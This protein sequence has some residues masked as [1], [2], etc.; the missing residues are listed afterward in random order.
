MGNIAVELRNLNLEYAEVI[1]L[2]NANLKFKKGSIHALI[3]EHGAGKS[4]I[5]HILSGLVKPSLGEIIIDEKHY[6]S[7]TPKIAINKGIHLVHQ[8][9]PLNPHFTVAENLFYSS[10]KSPIFSMFYKSQLQEKAK[11]YLK[12]KGFEIDTSRLTKNLNLAEKAVISILA[13]IVDNTNVLILDESLDKVSI[14]YY[15]HLTEI[16]NELAAKGCTI[17]IIS[18]KI[19]RVY[20][21]ADTISIVKD[22]R[23]I[24]TEDTKSIGKMQMIKMA[25]TQ[26]SE[27][28]IYQNN[29]GSLYQLVKYNEA[30]L[31]DLPANLIIVNNDG[32]LKLAN[33]FFINNF[34]LN[35]ADYI[36]KPVK[37]LFEK[38][39]STSLNV[40]LHSISDNKEETKFHVT[41]EINNN[42]GIF[43]IYTSPIIDDTDK[44]GNMIIF[45][46]ITVY[47]SLQE[48]NQLND[49]LSSVGLLSAGV[50]HEI[51]NPLEIISNYLTNIKFQYN[52][53]HLISIVN[54]LS[55]QVNYIT[56]IVS[57]LQ[58]FSNIEKLNPES[59]NVNEII[60]EMI[61]LLKVNA[62]LKDI[63]IVFVQNDYNAYIFVNEN[64]LK[65]VI[66]N[67]FK[68][69]FESIVNNGEVEIRIKRELINN[70]KHVSIY[71]TDTG[72]GID[73]TKDYFNP[74]FSTKSAN[75]KNTGMG[76]SLVY[77]I[78]SKYNGNI[79]LN[80]RSDG[81]KGCTVKV[82]FPEIE[83]MD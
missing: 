65:Q 9:L 75:H 53:E 2:Q 77:G 83:E 8:S 45:Y 71:F 3:G 24:L 28:P 54:K 48:N 27:T 41:L 74:F 55:K 72:T 81:N 31:E 16:F 76:L 79:S 57:N 80:N 69:A 36:E 82:T 52:D 33:K 1:A 12:T 70:T 17:I 67:I 58:N 47:N 6:P 19:D 14:N 23:I 7:L 13:Q 34:K 20:D 59:A 64:E 30:I 44:I 56:K 50:A 21:I 60:S 42:K 62:R 73:E 11:E 66:L 37:L 32:T 40:L 18:H 39:Q 15:A 25:Y 5:G 78:V 35:I 38:S 43:N 29:L 63:S 46:D 10:K 49:K 68:N 22:S 26:Y 61:G 4:S 51:N